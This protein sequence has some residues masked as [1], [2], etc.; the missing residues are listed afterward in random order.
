[1]KRN[2]SGYSVLKVR[3]LISLIVIG[4]Y[5]IAGIDLWKEYHHLGM[6]LFPALLVVTFCIAWMMSPVKIRYNGLE[7]NV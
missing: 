4:A 5:S 3:L 6:I 7:Q 1:M 2:R